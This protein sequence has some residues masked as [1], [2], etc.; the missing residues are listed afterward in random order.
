MSAVSSVARWI[1]V[2]VD[3]AY[4][5][6]VHKAILYDLLVEMFFRVIIIVRS[7]WVEDLKFREVLQIV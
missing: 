4:V 5:A 1:W 3:A 6:K 7:S 2:A